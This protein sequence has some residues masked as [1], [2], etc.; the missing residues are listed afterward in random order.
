MWLLTADNEGRSTL[1]AGLF[2]LRFN[3][4]FLGAHTED[5]DSDASPA[6]RKSPRDIE[7]LKKGVLLRS[8]Q[9]PTSHPLEHTMKRFIEKHREKING[10]L[11]CF[12]RIIFKG[13]LPLGYPKAMEEFMYRQGLLLKDFKSF[14]TTCSEKLKDHAKAVAEKNS[15]PYIYFN[16]AIRKDEFVQ[17]LAQ[18]DNITEG[19]ICVLALV[20]Q[21]QSFKLAYGKGK[22][23][24]V[25]AK[26][27]C[28]C[29]YFYLIDR[30][31]GFMHIR[32]QTWFP[33]VVQIYIN[34]HEWLARKIE[35]HGL[36]FHREGNAFLWLE[37]PRRAQRFADNMLRKNWPRILD[38][39]ASRVN[40]HLRDL[41]QPMLYYW[42]IDQAEFATDILFHN[43]PCLKFL[44]EKLLR[45]ATVCFSAEDVMT[46]LGRKLNGNFKGEILSDSKKRWPGARI[47]HR[48]KA[49]GIKMYDKHGSVLR[50]ETVINH[51]Y[52]FRV[53]RMGKRNGESVLGWFPMVKRVTNMY[54]YAEVCL[55]A[56]CRYLDALSVIDDPSQAYRL[57]HR[58]CQPVNR[59]GQRR[60]ALNPLCQK[61]LTLFVA[62]LR[63]EHFI[64]GF[65]NRELGRHLNIEPSRDNGE[66][67]RQSARIT[68]LLQ[69][70]RA[71]GLIAKIP[72]TRRYRLSIQGA[73]L[74]SAAVYLR[75]EQM[76][77]MIQKLAA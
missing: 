31:F 34:G 21:C 56:N 63:G 70:L 62:V 9:F 74:M 1:S 29:I 24:I 7:D 38:A 22:P 20:E 44:Y 3:S 45:H 71:H 50:I 53:Y 17:D 8:W 35:K 55:A 33:F 72:R 65:S 40:P 28:L 68:R 19:L 58:V 46:F 77:E 26:P 61:D 2:L 14:V 60:R 18:K 27:K 51:P 69:L 47:K 73:A 42:V 5:H 25:A 41:L 66:R 54:R 11:S 10:T 13:H 39:F 36:D 76:P 12:D 23:R 32:I 48:M 57:L 64:H 59:N 4:R 30:E 52:E 16:H 49:N 43:R 67:K 15:R 37:D 75:K 6:T